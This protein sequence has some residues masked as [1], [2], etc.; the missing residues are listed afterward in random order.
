MARHKRESTEILNRNEVSRRE[1]LQIA[2]AAAGLTLLPRLAAANAR[3]IRAEPALATLA[4]EAYPQT[5][6][7]TYGGTVPGT[8]L[9]FK[10]GER[11]RVELQ[12]LL[13][14]DTT[15]HWHGVRLPNAMDGVPHVTQAPIAAKGGRFLYEFDLRDAGT[16][17]YHPHLGSPGQVGR[18][19]YAPLIVEEP[20]PPTV[21]RDVL[22]MLGDWRLDRQ[23][24]IVEDFGNFMD[25]SHDGRIGNTV[26]VNGAI[27]EAF[28][29]HA[30]ERIRLRLVNAANA[31]I[32]ALEFRGHEPLVI[33]LD[34]HPV[35]PH[36]A[37]QGRI[38]LG[39]AMRA[40]VLLDAKGEPGRSYAVV[41]DFYPR[42][43][44]RLLDLGYAKQPLRHGHAGTPLPKLASNPLSEPDVAGA[45]R[46]RIEFGGGMMGGM[47]GMGMMRGMVWTV[48]GKSMPD[49]GH[50]HAAPILKLGLGRSYVLELAN[51]TQWHH[52]I[53]LHGH[54]FRVLTREGRST[55]HREWLD[56]V[57]LPPRTRAEIVF[58]ADNPGNWMLH[59]HVLEHQHAGMMAVVRV[60]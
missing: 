36:R 46:H 60:A 20:E 58:V 27:R 11:L 14:E 31:R 6:V 49:D 40:D 50:E 13:P 42:R 19:L 10:Q 34:G 37:E 29:L 44:Y 59:C 48:N 43:A 12:N 18:G 55:R 8:E 16:Y 54:V 22:W 53:H 9:R 45:E 7:W 4:G 5:A 32:F 38:V 57:L 52:P 25:A 51:Q 35:E 56:T 41:D 26:T 15:V 28:E 39:P 23:A 2:G 30:G 21:D 1:F 33:A 3:V 47:M 17:W 24:R